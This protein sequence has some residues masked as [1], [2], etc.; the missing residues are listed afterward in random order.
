MHRSP[1]FVRAVLL[2]LMVSSTNIFAPLPKHREARAGST[3][4]A[5]AH[6]PVVIAR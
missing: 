3:R 5:L 4:S 6:A 2:G 1:S